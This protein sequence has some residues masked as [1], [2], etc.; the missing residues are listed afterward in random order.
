MKILSILSTTFIVLSL[1]SC[2]K[3]TDLKELQGNLIDETDSCSY[4]IDGKQFACDRMVSFE[5]GNA[6]ANLDSATR[7]W[8]SDTSQYR[9]SFTLIKSEDENMNDNGYLKISFIK[10]Y[11]KNQ[12]TKTWPIGILGPATEME[13]YAKGEYSYAMDYNR[14]NSGNGVAI[15]VLNRNDS[16][17]EHLLTYIYASAFSSTTIGPDSQK[18]SRFEILQMRSLADGT[19]L[20]EAKFTANVF[21]WDEKAKKLENGYLRIHV[22]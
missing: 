1:V 4:T 9:N 14:S 21:N 18:N 8:N 11:G 17:V 10:K 20:L 16:S 12:L 3:N 22:D 5:R 2:T 13:L 7:Q 6:G 19:H 15:D